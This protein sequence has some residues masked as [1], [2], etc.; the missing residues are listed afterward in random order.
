MNDLWDTRVDDDKFALLVELE[1]M[2]EAR[3]K[4][5]V[6]ETDSFT[7]NEVIMQGSVFSSLKCS[8]SIDS[9]GRDCLSSEEETGLYSYKGIVSVPP[10]SVVDDILTITKCGVDNL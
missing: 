5:P 9:L 4:T 2:C 7:L 1:R 6:G 3:V 10:L 8:I